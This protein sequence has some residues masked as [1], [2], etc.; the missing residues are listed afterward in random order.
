MTWWDGAP[1]E[2]KL[3]DVLWAIAFLVFI[4]A[5]VAAGLTL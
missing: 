3:V 5:V 1:P 2:R 4:A